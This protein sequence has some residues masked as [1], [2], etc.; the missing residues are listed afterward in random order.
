MNLT[1]TIPWSPLSEKH[2]DYISADFDSRFCY[3]D[4]A[5]RKFA[6]LFQIEIGE[7]GGIKMTAKICVCLAFALCALSVYFNKR[8]EA[9]ADRFLLLA[10]T[11]MFFGFVTLWS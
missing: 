2:V 8:N 9:W 6:N 10:Y 5:F 4:G 11:A 3:S 1:R 7:I